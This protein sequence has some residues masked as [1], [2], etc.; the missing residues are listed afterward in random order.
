MYMAL[1]ALSHKAKELIIAIEST[2]G[3]KHCGRE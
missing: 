1:A 2:V 3:G